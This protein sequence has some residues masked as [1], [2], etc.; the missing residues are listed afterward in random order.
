MKA[1]Y[2]RFMNVMMLYILLLFIYV[3]FQST[4]SDQPIVQWLL[5]GLTIYAMMYIGLGSLF[6]L[7]LFI[8]FFPFS[9]LILPLF[10]S[11]PYRIMRC[12]GC[13]QKIQPTEYV[14]IKRPSTS[15]LHF[16]SPKED[17][18]WSYR[19]TCQNNACGYY[20]REQVQQRR[21]HYV[22][23]SHRQLEYW[24]H[25]RKWTILDAAV[26]LGPEHM[27]N[28]GDNTYIAHAKDSSHPS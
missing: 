21:K 17:L 19:G 14:Y 10:Q 22:W 1:S 2:Y 26:D 9:L 12:K 4:L 8:T 11:N 27:E 13:N 18:Y 28:V 5:G 3:P 24:Q 7:S 6:R 20:H 16:L 23:V 25:H 15:W